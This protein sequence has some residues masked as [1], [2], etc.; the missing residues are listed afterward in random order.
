MSEHCGRCHQVVIRNIKTSHSRD[1]VLQ[2]VPSL[3]EEER[4]VILLSHYM[5]YFVSFPRDL[6][7]LRSCC[8][9]S[10]C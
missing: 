10:E 8:L 4:A 6:V 1:G 3:D 5:L 9:L 7:E 2:S